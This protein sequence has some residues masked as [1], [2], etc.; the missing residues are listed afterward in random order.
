[1]A[2]LGVVL[3]VVLL[4]AANI[5]LFLSCEQKDRSKINLKAFDLSG[6]IA[7]MGDIFSCGGGLCLV[8]SHGT[9]RA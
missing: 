2:P 7:A 8:S 5:P 9:R 4:T 1:M 3:T 6:G